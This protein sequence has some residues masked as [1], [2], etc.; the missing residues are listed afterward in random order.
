MD[1]LLTPPSSMRF[2]GNLAKNWK[3]FKQRFNIYLNASGAGG[4]DEKKKA[5]ILLHVIGEEAL[6]I[7]NSFHISDGELKL[8]VIMTKFE[9]YKHYIREINVF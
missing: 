9:E 7:Y 2:D 1:N 4:D 5:S 8:D 3:R 6:E